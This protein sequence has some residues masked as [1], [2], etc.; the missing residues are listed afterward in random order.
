MSRI[1]QKPPYTG[2]GLT[3]GPEPVRASETP[4]GGHAANETAAFVERATR[5]ARRAL[6][7]GSRSLRPGRAFRRRGPLGVVCRVLDTEYSWVEVRLD[8]PHDDDAPSA[9]LAEASL[10]AQPTEEA[11]R[12]AIRRAM[13]KACDRLDKAAR[14]AAEL[15]GIVGRRGGVR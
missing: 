9:V 1:D 4:H 10:S 6:G 3:D 5:E 11:W 12:D 15:R 8:L 13:R 2:T 7:R 14:A